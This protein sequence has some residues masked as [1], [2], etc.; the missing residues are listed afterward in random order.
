MVIEPIHC[1]PTNREH[2]FYE[3]MDIEAAESQAE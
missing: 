1:A 2:T 3:Y